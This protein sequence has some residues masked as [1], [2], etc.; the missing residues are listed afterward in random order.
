[1]LRMTVSR[2]ES[3]AAA[4]RGTGVTGIMSAMLSSTESASAL[5]F[6]DLSS[7]DF[8]RTPGFDSVQALTETGV[9]K[10]TA[11]RPYRFKLPVRNRTRLK[12]M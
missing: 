12:K 4:T 9:P 3:N 10:F 1:M 11:T 5:S 7:R 8:S 6:G 2:N